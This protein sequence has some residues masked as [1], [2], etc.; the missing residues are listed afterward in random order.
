MRISASVVADRS[1]MWLTE[2][3]CDAR[4]TIEAATVARV[5]LFRPT[6]GFRHYYILVEIASGTGSTSH[7]SMGIIRLD[8]WLRACF[9]VLIFMLAWTTSDTF[10]KIINK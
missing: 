9:P 8:E 1:L 10:G 6:Y 2:L 5:N 7:W 3:C 4:I